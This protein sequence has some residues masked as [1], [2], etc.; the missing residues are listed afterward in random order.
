MLTV[1]PK[2]V[3]DEAVMLHGHLGPFLVL[4][5]KMGLKA[6]GIIGRPVAC[7]VVTL[8]RKPYLCVVDGLKTVMVDNIVV[9]EGDGL[10]A[11]FS[12]SNGDEIS[13]RIKKT[14]VEKYA[15]SPWKKCK[16]NAYEVMNSSDEELFENWPLKLK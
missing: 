9:R 15:E 14:I 4:G 16:E 2:D 3:L 6:R 1:I 8:R 12:N 10:S 11:R 5:L 7:E 13:I